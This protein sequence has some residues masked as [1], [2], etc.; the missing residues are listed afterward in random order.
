MALDAQGKVLALRVRTLA[1]MGAYPRNASVAIQLLVG[2]GSPPASTTSRWWISPFTALLTNTATTG[3][4]GGAG[5]PEA[6]YL[7]ERLM[8]TAARQMGLDPAELRRRNM[9]APTQ[10]PY[11]KPRR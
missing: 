5:R 8:D 11:K 9:I 3:P 2:S 4:H 1:D 6:I 10:M 7:L